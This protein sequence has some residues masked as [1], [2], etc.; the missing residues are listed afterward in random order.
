MESPNENKCSLISHQLLF[1]ILS[2]VVKTIFTFQPVG[3]MRNVLERPP[4][5]IPGRSRE[6]WRPALSDGSWKKTSVFEMTSQRIYFSTRPCHMRRAIP[7]GWWRSGPKTHKSALMNPVWGEKKKKKKKK[8]WE[9]KEKEAPAEK[10]G[11]AFT[12]R[13]SG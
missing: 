9:K 5:W 3:R 4:V 7:R 2:P 10:H 1:G 13:G 11:G 8:K 12:K 6:L